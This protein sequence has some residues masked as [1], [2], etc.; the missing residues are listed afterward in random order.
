MAK[1]HLSPIV[2]PNTL[3][4]MI[5]YMLIS[6]ILD[7]ICEMTKKLLEYPRNDIRLNPLQHL[8]KIKT[9]GTYWKKVIDKTNEHV[10]WQ[11]MQK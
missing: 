6:N 9:W 2:T 11:Q 5:E 4:T 8:L 7:K 3:E 10:P 1:K